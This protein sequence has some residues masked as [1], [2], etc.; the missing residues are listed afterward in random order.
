MTSTIAGH[1]PFS[2]LPSTATK[3]HQFSALQPHSLLSVGTFCDHGYTAKFTATDV[4]IANASDNILTGIRM[5]NGLWGIPIPDTMPGTTNNHF[6]NAIVPTHNLPKLMAY[7]HASLFSPSL[8]TLLKAVRNNQLS[9]WP[10]LTESNIKKYL[11]PSLATA[12]GHLDQSRQNQQST[13]TLTAKNVEDPDDII[14]QDIPNERSHHVYAA[15]ETYPTPRQL[16]Y[17]DQTGPFPSISTQGNKLLLVL[18]EYDSNTILVEPLVSRNA[19]EIKR[20]YEKLHKFLCQRGFRPKFQRLDNEASS[21]LKDYFRDN[22]IDFQLAPPGVHRR[23][24]AERAIHTFKNHFVAG[25]CTT[26]PAF[27]IGL[28]DKL[29]QQATYSLNLLRTSRLHPQLSSFAHL[30]GNF[31]FNRTPFAPPGIKVIAHEKAPQRG[32]WAP[33]G[34]AG[35]YIG[36]SMEHYRCYKVH[37]IKTGRE[38]DVDTVQFFPHYHPLPRA[39][40][41]EQLVTATD[42]LTKVLREQQN[43]S[44]SAKQTIDQFESLF[45][46]TTS[47]LPR[48]PDTKAT[49][50]AISH[51]N[52]PVSGLSVDCRHGAPL[53]YPLPRVPSTLTNH[54]PPDTKQCDFNTHGGVGSAIPPFEFAAAVRHPT[55]GVSMEYRALIRDPVTTEAWTKS[56]AN[57][58]GRLAQGLACRNIAGTNTIHFIHPHQVPSNKKPTYPRVVCEEKPHKEEK[59]R[60]RVTVGGNLIDYPG[61]KSTPTGDLTTLKLHI[62]STLSTPGAKMMLCDLKNYYLG[63]TL[64]EPEFMKIPLAIIPQEI[65]DQYQLLQFVTKDGYVYVRISKGMYG[66][67]QAGILA[68]QQ[69]ERLLNPHG[70]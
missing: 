51:R 27:P 3:A 36:P 34:V 42:N 15:I 22:E 5:P 44:A 47:S 70:Y 61:D 62:N 56:A 6:A 26:D 35:W 52:N 1:L 12:L 19:S 20:A 7:L 46:P 25:L 28:W 69:L 32:S 13:K 66:L 31:D 41:Q 63:T 59:E 17:T 38:R 48:V 50:N 9:T 55:T 65:I 57:E 64:P 60:T 49:A 53:Q 21:L 54:H 30:W 45:K 16:V 18:Y 4:T 40:I 24:A 43:L 33:H 58:F 14:L 39:T 23:N 37:V 10:K 67:P 11:Q 29:L 2:A 8:S 68:N